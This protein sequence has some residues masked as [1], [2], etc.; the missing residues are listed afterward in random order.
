[1]GMYKGYYT[2]KRNGKTI[3]LK[4]HIGKGSSKDARY[5]IRVGFDYDETDRVV[6]IG[7]LGQHQ[8]TGAT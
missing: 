8:K 4:S 1:M 2:T 3:K 7:F 5:C 6:V